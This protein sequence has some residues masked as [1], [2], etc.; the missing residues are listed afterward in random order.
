MRRDERTRARL[1]SFGYI[2]EEVIIMLYGEDCGRFVLQEET[3]RKRTIS[4]VLGLSDSGRMTRSGTGVW[5]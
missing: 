3:A 5:E 2:R 4:S 1:P